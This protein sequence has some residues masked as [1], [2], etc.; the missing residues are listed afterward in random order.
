MKAIRKHILTVALLVAALTI[1]TIPALALANWILYLIYERKK[2]P[3]NDAP[4]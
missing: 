4:N 3:Q 1:L 2:A